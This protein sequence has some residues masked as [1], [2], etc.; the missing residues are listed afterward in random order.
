MTIEGRLR[1]HSIVMNYKK[2]EH[3]AFRYVP[4]FL[5]FPYLL[6]QNN[7]LRT[8]L[9]AETTSGTFFLIDISDVVNNMYC[10]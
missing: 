6:L 5:I 7:L 4:L 3:T 1:E 10:I 2:E 9:S 8:L